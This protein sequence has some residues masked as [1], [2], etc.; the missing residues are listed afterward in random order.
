V[1]YKVV[2]ESTPT[3]AEVSRIEALLKTS[4]NCRFNVPC[5]NCQRY[6]VLH[7][8]RLKWDRLPNGEHDVDVAGR[9]AR[10]HCD[11]C[12]EPCHDHHRAWMMR[13][14]VWL[15]HNCQIDHEKALEV[16][17]RRNQQLK[18]GTF[19]DE[20]AGRYWK[21]GYAIGE[22][23]RD[24]SVAGYQLSSLYALSLT[25]GRIAEEW[26]SVYQVPVNRRNFINSWLG[27][28]FREKK[29]SEKWES[30]ARRLIVQIPRGMAPLWASLLT[31]GIDR[32]KDHYKWVVDAWGP[33]GMSHTMDYGRADDLRS[34][35]KEQILRKWQ[36]ADGGTI[37]VARAM[38]D[39]GFDPE[40]P[41]TVSKECL[42]ASPRIVLLCCH[43]SSRPLQAPFKITELD[44]RTIMPGL[45]YVL[46]DGDWTQLGLERQL[47]ELRPGESGAMSVFEAEPAEHEAF[48]RELLNDEPIWGTDRHNNP[49]CSWDRI[50]EADPNDH[51]DCRR[52][53]TVGQLIYTEGKPILSRDQ[54]LAKQMPQVTAPRLIT[55]D[56]RPFMAAPRR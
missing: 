4:S 24:G 20:P 47:H 18:E 28:T 30:L 23:T 25:W 36:H 34:I 16:A 3:V 41:Y 45:P 56:G 11:H 52:D 33:G 5:P 51:R 48:F 21:H 26:I 35:L 17:E 13:R 1:N 29:R 19:S 50:T 15:P 37:E 55:P 2:L 42:D 12:N 43:G 7:F 44:E 31:M 49:Q 53:S 6:Q 32:Q 22:P 54:E 14:G 9:T 38:V 8:A 46:V 10:Y 27:E 40:E 39:A